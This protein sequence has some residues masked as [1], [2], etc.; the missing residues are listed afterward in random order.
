MDFENQEASIEQPPSDAK[1]C[2]YQ[3]LWHAA[4]FILPAFS[5]R[6]YRIAHRKKISQALIFFV[7]FASVLSALSTL[8]VVRIIRDLDV[9]LQAAL[10]SGDFPV[11]TIRDGIANIDA[12]Q[13]MVLLDEE[14][15]LFALDT[16]G[17]YTS[18]DPQQY[19]E[20]ILLT[21]T[22]LQVMDST[23]AQNTLLLS[24][25]NELFR[26]NPIVID[27][28]F[29]LDAWEGFSRVAVILAAI[30]LWIWHVFIRLLLIS[31]LGL[32]IWGSISALRSRTDF[33]SI[34]VT[35]IYALVPALY[36]HY[37]LSRGGLALP[38]LQ[39]MILMLTWLGITIANIGQI[40]R[41]VV[42]Q[43]EVLLRMTPIGIPMLLVLAWDVV[44]TP[45]IEP[46]ALWVIPMLTFVVWMVMRRFQAD[47][48]LPPAGSS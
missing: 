17:V 42:G 26:T 36:L 19:R 1:G 16:S 31:V 27:D 29:V 7:L 33:V 23:G 37:L 22:E 48:D 43:E 30:G 13:P 44:F 5:L 41:S 45:P 2:G 21:R 8:R 18:I 4:L 25:L 39:T 6:F 3:I 34:M 32:L 40:E 14:G 38:G 35:G 24:E 10:E 11:I 46:F 28:L 12:P 20:G 47:D 15:Q 9:Q